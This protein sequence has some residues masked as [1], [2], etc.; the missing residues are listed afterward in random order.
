MGLKSQ[1]FATCLVFLVFQITAVEANDLKN[2]FKRSQKVKFN[3]SEDSLCFSNDGFT[4][5]VGYNPYFQILARVAD[6]EG[7]CQGMVATAAS[8]KRNVVFKPYKKA[9]SKAKVESIIARAKELHYNDCDKKIEIHGYHNLRDLCQAHEDLFRKT[10]LDYNLQIA[11][12]DILTI[13]SFFAKSMLNTK[14]EVSEH[15][16]ETLKSMYNDLKE[17]RYPLMLVR[18]H[19]TVVLA[20]NIEF[21]EDDNPRRIELTFYDPNDLMSSEEDYRFRNYTISRDGLIEGRLIWNITK[22]PMLNG[23]YCWTL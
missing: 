17:G 20:M 10:S 22:R 3:P 21:D 8:F 11:K 2:I 1:W 7:A 16:K 13:P 4:P 14:E 23:A 18:K 15:L 5:F 12:N 6:K 9:H 19:V